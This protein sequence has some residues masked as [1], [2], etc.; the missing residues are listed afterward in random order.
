VKALADPAFVY[1]LNEYVVPAVPVR[2]Q[3]QLQSSAPPEPEAPVR[4][5]LPLE[6]DPQMEMTVVLVMVVTTLI[7]SEPLVVWLPPNVRLEVFA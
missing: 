1:V 3:L 7:V 5:T 2:S 6:V 4:S